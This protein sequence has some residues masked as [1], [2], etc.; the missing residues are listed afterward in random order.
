M[1]EDRQP[2]VFVPNWFTVDFKTGVLTYTSGRYSL[3]YILN[4]YSQFTPSRTRMIVSLPGSP[5][6]RWP[7]F[8]DTLEQKVNYGG[9]LLQVLA[10]TIYD[11]Q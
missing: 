10:V 11:H 6:E 3:Y 9:L 1:V 5:P 4:Q 2:T 7:G 8:N